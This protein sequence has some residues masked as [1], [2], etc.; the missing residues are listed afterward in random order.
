M[1][2]AGLLLN[3]FLALD[4][5]KAKPKVFKILFFKPVLLIESHHLLLHLRPA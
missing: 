3:N 1:I 5:I 4:M 2:T